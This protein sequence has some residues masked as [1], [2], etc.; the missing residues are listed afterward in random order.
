M[1]GYV[2][3]RNGDKYFFALYPTNSNSQALGES[4]LYTGEKECLKALDDFKLLVKINKIDSLI[5]SNIS[6][7]ENEKMKYLDN[8]KNPVF[9]T[10]NKY[11]K[12]Y[13]FN[14]DKTIKS[15]YR[16]IDSELKFEWV[17]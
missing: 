14:C 17:K 15:I 3:K 8:K 2:I 5:S 16:N 6:Y 12:N 10:R 7:E 11:S 13:K 1:P 4:I 9:Y